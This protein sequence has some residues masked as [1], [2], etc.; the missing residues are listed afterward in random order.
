MQ[1]GE[2]EALPEEQR[3]RVRQFPRSERLHPGVEGGP[4][5]LRRQQAHQADEEQLGQEGLYW[6]HEGEEG[7]V[8]QQ[9]EE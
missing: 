5:D 1:S 8:H 3:L 9:Q 4:R 6:E 2:E 7:G